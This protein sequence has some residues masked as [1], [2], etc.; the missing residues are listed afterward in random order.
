MSG[1]A[2]ECPSPGQLD[3]GNSTDHEEFGSAWMSLHFL[4]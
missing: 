3:A 1:A 2:E 4:P